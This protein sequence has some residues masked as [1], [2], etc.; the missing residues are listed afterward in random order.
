MI[1]KENISDAAC[2]QVRARIADFVAETLDDKSHEQVRRHILNCAACTRLLAQ[3]T[4]ESMTPE[5]TA[6][7]SRPMPRP[8]EAIRIALGVREER[9]G[10][11]WTNL[12]QLAKGRADWARA[13][14][15]ELRH[16][17]QHWLQALIDAPLSV[18]K[19][20]GRRGTDEWPEQLEV[21]VVDAAGQPFGQSLRCEV[22]QAPVVTKSGE[23]YCHLRASSPN[24]SGG[25]LRC[26]VTLADSIKVTFTG[27]WTQVGPRQWMVTLKDSGLP[28]LQ[29]PVELPEQSVAFAVVT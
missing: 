27:N 26:T 7:F 8:P 13:E 18:A 12:Q 24:F 9:E 17:W 5:L 1:K 28:V 11:L 25:S 19:G 20:R 4:E 23:L 22:I 6:Q 3:A 2:A 29:E 15:E 21:P 10:T 16:S 14:W